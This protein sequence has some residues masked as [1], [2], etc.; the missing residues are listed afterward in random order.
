M[1]I[2][3]SWL[4]E[5]VHFTVPV[6]TLAEDLTM[7]G[8]EV[9]EMEPAYKG[10]APVVVCLVE[11]IVSHPQASH[12]Q[13]CTVA[14]GEQKFEVVCGA[15]NVENGQ[16]A[17]LARPGTVLSDGTTVRSS[18]IYGIRSD[19]MLCSEAELGIGDDKTG[20]L[21]LEPAPGCKAGNALVDVMGLKDWVLDIAVTPNRPDCLSVLG[22]AREVS[23]IYGIPLTIPQS[24]NRQ[25]VKS[26]N[27][28]LHRR[29]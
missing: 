20:I 28:Y 2:L 22:V 14:A 12:L 15:P 26:S 10:L 17:A 23:A 3:T 18:D 16:L 13:V 29:P 27:S 7:T 19:G 6:E 8:L 25:I 11:K 9:E 4:K 24:S 1:R 5:F 21:V